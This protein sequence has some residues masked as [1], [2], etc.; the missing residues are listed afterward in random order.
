MVFNEPY[1][2]APSREAAV[3]RIMRIAGES[4]S[5]EQFLQKDISR[6]PAGSL[7]YPAT[8]KSPLVITPLA[9]PVLVK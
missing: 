2:N 5:M 3:R 1:Y 9:P 7:A 6:A 4:F 8:V